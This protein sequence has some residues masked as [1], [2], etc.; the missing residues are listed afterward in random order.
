[1]HSGVCK[2]IDIVHNSTSSKY[3]CRVCTVQT[4]THVGVC[5]CNTRMYT[6]VLLRSNYG[7]YSVELHREKEERDES[8]FLSMRTRGKREGMSVRVFG[9]V[10][11]VWGGRTHF[12]ICIYD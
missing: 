9:V 5:T 2:Y 7:N 6:C 10:W 4:R 1:M 8:L 11:R 12:N 3:I